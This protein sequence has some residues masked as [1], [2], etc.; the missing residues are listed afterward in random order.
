MYK[1]EE[2]RKVSK[3]D[4]QLSHHI[5]AV[6]PT[7]LAPR[8]CIVHEHQYGRLCDDHCVYDYTVNTIYG[9]HT[10]VC[11]HDQFETQQVCLPSSVLCRICLS[12]T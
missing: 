4:C 12:C 5:A 8:F 3:L 1:E 2:T 7:K 9:N 11:S 10:L 6:N